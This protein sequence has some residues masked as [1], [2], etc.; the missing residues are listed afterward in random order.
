MI[1]SDKQIRRI[2]CTHVA[3]VANRRIITQTEP[4]SW[5]CPTAIQ[6]VCQQCGDRLMRHAHAMTAP[7]GRSAGLRL[8]RVSVFALLGITLLGIITHPSAS[9]PLPSGD[10]STLPPLCGAT[11]N[12]SSNCSDSCFSGCTYEDGKWA[13]E[14]STCGEAATLACPISPGPPSGGGGTGGGV[15]P[16]T[17][18]PPGPSP[19]PPQAPSPAGPSPTSPQA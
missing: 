11:C 19:T 4:K 9:Q 3:N 1:G 13:C 6:A 18:S 7:F 10:I 2:R 16:P 17:P 15:G 12:S 5:C 8:P 14:D